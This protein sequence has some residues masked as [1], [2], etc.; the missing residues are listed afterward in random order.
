[1]ETMPSSLPMSLRREALRCEIKNDFGLL[2]L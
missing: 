1:M 2:T